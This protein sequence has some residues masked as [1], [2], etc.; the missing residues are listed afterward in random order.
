MKLSWQIVKFKLKEVFAIAYG[1]YTFR[2]ALIV[3]LQQNGEKGYGECTAID[4]YQI[5]IYDYEKQLNRVKSQLEVQKMVHPSAFYIFL[6]TLELPS[7]L[8]SALDC[9]YWDLYG[10]LERKS[11]LEL[12]SISYTTL[13]ESSITISIDTVYNQIK[14]IQDSSW[15]KFKV[16][17]N[18]YDEQHILKLSQIE[19][20]IA[21]DANGSFTIE[22]CLAIENNKIASKFMY[23]EQPMKKGAENYS[24]LH[25]NTFA[26]WMADEDCQASI[27]LCH[28]TSHY[29]SINIKL[30]KCGGLTPAIE[31]ISKSRELGYQIMIGCMTESTIG[32]SAGAVLAPLCDYADLDGANLIANDIAI[33]SHIIEGKIVVSEKPG[34]GI[35]LM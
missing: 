34:L 10:K 32:I 5:N 9:A 12:N 4:Y 11:F 27:D 2:E 33:G 29:K 6:L 28:L 18:H 30:V 31:M 23:L 15:N 20:S 8:R 13:I 19:R 14:K 3:T 1:N 21:L 16:K 26:N 25:S 7:F 35:K 17:C 24:N 22:Q